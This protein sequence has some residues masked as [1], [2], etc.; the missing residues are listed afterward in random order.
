M[1]VLPSEK[2]TVVVSAT[3]TGTGVGMPRTQATPA[4]TLAP[5][6]RTTVAVPPRI[7]RRHSCRARCRTA[8]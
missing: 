1:T 5:E 3:A 8:A 2:Y 4:A 7:R 6:S